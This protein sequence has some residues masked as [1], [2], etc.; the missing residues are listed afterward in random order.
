MYVS[1]G[2][3]IQRQIFWYGYYEKES[4]LTWERFINGQTTV[5]DIGANIGYYSLV[6]SPLAG[7]I[8]SFEPSAGIRELLTKNI[9]FNK[10]NNVSIQPFAVSNTIGQAKFYKS[11]P[12]NSGMS[13]LSEPENFSGKTETVSVITLDEWATQN[14]IPKISIIKADLEGAEMNLLSGMKKTL[15]AHRPVLFLEVRNELL[16]K[17]GYRHTD[18]FDFLLE[19]G[20]SGY[21]IITQGLLKSLDKPIESDHIVFLP[22]NYSL[23]DG[24]M[25]K[26]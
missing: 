6:A 14:D 23:P 21:E 7:K 11:M 12:E 4:I 24:I 25:I 17:F 1:P 10:C 18:I 13:G 26:E 15:S 19:Y 20:Y 8:Y 2:D 3:H 22:N 9:A 5:L 16:S